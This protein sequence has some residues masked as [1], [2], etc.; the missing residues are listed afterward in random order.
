MVIFRPGVRLGIVLVHLAVAAQVGNY[1]EMSPATFDFARE[2]CADL[3]SMR[4]LARV[5]GGL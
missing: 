5:V 3:V 2:S 4:N 1:R